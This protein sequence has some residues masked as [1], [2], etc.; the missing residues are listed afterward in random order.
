MDLFFPLLKLRIQF[1]DLIIRSFQSTSFDRIFRRSILGSLEFDRK[2]QKILSCPPISDGATQ[3][4]WLPVYSAAHVNP[5]V[6]RAW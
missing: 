6:L 1:S 2:L 5:A 4:P 3:L